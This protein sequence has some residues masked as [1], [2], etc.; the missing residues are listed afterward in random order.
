MVEHLTGGSTQDIV[1]IGNL[2]HRRQSANATF[3]H[4]LLRYL[5]Q[6]GFSAAPRFRG[7]DSH[8]REQ[9]TYI[10]GTVVHDVGAIGWTDN[11]L[12]HVAKL[13]RTFHDATADSPLAGVHEVVCHN[14]AA[15]WN[16]V[17]VDGLPAALID[18]DEAAPGSRIRDVSYALW[19]WLNLGDDHISPREQARRIRLFC[20]EYGLMRRDN[21]VP[22]IIQRQGEI[23]AMR[24]AKGHDELAV[25]VANERA[26]LQRH[27][28]ELGV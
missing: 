7:I 5:E 28:A 3:V 12:R 23:H 27:A 14:D 15:P 2:V 19:C 8:G 13:L 6:V 26:W 4:S 9:L 17:L 11:Q 16:V 24:M 18:F 1:R 20:D 22:E 21:L 25:R 10:D